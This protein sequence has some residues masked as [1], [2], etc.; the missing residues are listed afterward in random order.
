MKKF[1]ITVSI[2]LIFA[3][4]KLSSDNSK[5][6]VEWQLLKYRYIMEQ[7]LEFSADSVYLDKASDAAY[8]AFL[9]E[10]NQDSKYFDKEVMERLLNREKNLA[11]GIGV[12]Y[13]IAD[14]TV[15]VLK[16]KTEQMKPSSSIIKIDNK[17][18]T[19]MNYQQVNA[20]ISG[21][22]DTDII[23]E[24][25]YEGK[26]EKLIYTRKEYKTNAVTSAFDINESGKC[27]IKLDRFSENSAFELSKSLDSLNRINELSYII[28]DLRG[29]SGGL[30][31]EVIESL[32]LFFEDN[33]F[34]TEIKSKSEEYAKKYYT[35][36][37]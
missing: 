3:N 17:P 34:I 21:E 1:I 25:L 22:P 29:N 31:D 30:I 2:L 5:N 19:G 6:D 36:G 7:V 4:L 13:I 10:I 14:D 27:Y 11:V 23:V 26:T 9:Q 8:N 18:V 15:K 28:L 35:K 12:E 33:T 37:T 24:S 20:L 16:D 32:S